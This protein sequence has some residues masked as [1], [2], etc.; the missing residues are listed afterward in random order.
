MPKLRPTVTCNKCQKEGHY[1]NECQSKINEKS[2]DK[3][4]SDKVPNINTPKFRSGISCN[5]CQKE[6]HY[7]SECQE[8]I[9]ER[10][11]DESQTNNINE[12]NMEKEEITQSDKWERFKEHD[13]S[14]EEEFRNKVD[15]R[16]LLKTD[17]PEM[18]TSLPEL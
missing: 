9:K 6:G 12:I 11:K 5:K 17:E 16:S 7:A 4:I 13:K 2:N 14:K 8:K 10:I 18:I 3:S 1:S 15:V